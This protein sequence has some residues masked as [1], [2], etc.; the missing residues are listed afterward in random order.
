MACSCAERRKSIAE[1]RRA[2]AA[3]DKDQVK[4]QVKAIGRSIRRDLA[5]LRR[6]VTRK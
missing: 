2:A 5:G 6:L 4:V 3:G 1:I